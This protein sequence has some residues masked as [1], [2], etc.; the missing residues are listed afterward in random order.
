[1]TVA[2]RDEV[3]AEGSYYLEWWE[4]GSRYGEAAGPNGFAAADKVRAK[5]AELDAARNGIIPA[6]PAVEGSE[7][8]T[9]VLATAY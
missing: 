4:G 5:Q 6:S 7:E 1:V 8:R 9:T 3:H 2:G